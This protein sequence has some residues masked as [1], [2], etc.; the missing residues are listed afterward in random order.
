MAA[1]KSNFLFLLLLCLMACSQQPGTGNNTTTAAATDSVKAT[2]P[3]VDA[4][5]PMVQVSPAMVVPSLAV[6]NA[7]AD[8][9]ALYLPKGF[10]T[11]QPHA[12]IVFFDPHGDGRIPLEKYHQ[13]AD[14]YNTILAGSN[15]SR[16]GASLETGI[17]IAGRLIAD[18]SHRYKLD[19]RRITF[20]GFS[21][22]AKVAMMAANTI[23][24]VTDVVY[25]GAIVPMQ[26]FSRPISFLGIAGTH[27][28][29][30]SD[31]LQFHYSLG[32]SNPH[33]LLE[34]KGKHE[35]PEPGVFENAFVP[36]STIAKSKLVVV[37]QAKLAAITA[38]NN[39]KQYLLKSMQV[40]NLDWWKL[41]TDELRRKSATDAVSDRALGFISLACY[42]LGKNY[43]SSNDL[44]G[45]EKIIAIYKLADPGN[46]DCALYEK[47]LLA[48]KG[49]H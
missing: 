46:A 28:M 6:Q 9:F 16:N 40:E 32:S 15:T 44:P 20:C 21:G 30:Y 2:T 23:P 27:D 11:T 10:D 4:N 8:S 5:A 19:G 22:G 48:R 31:L 34:W 38:E 3:E 39:M 37:D 49:G 36:F 14:K 45:A 7:P 42:S 25:C 33:Y 29:N 18:L 1:I 43:L 17:S 26:N 41:K 35:W 13:L 12:I 47:E 24:T